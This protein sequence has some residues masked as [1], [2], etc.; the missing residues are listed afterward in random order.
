MRA[1]QFLV[2]NGYLPSRE[3]A[4]K[5][6]V[7]GDVL[8]D[9][10]PIRKP[11]EEIPDGAHT[12]EIRNPMRYV[13]R[14]GWK[15]EAAIKRFSMDISGLTALDIG[16]STG[17]FTDCLLQH[18]AKHVFAVDAGEGQLAEK[19]RSDPRVT[20]MEHC[21]ARYL[22]AAQI[23]RRVPL[24]VMDVSFISAT[25]ILP[26]FPE[27]LED[28]GEAVLLIKP[29]FEV[30]RAMIGKGGIVKDPRAHRAAVERVLEAGVRL[31]LVPT[32]LCR[33][34]V[35]GGDGNVEF[36]IRFRKE[37]GCLSRVDEATVRAVTEKQWSGEESSV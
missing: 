35:T 9:G 29:Q 32:D 6:I 18:G 5:Q 34:P 3:Q 4:K 24:I 25:C 37:T 13:G 19:L 27:L 1:D 28:G 15:L 8:C 11:S 26:V 10:K 33:S 20:S 30:G 14:G 16:A 7:S 36:L 21:N 31:G 17:G 23:G 2:A 12:V 22:T